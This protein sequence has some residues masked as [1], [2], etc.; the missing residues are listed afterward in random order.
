[1]FSILCSGEA[2]FY[3][4]LTMHYHCVEGHVPGLN[5]VG[6]DDNSWKCS[7]KGNALQQSAQAEP[8]RAGSPARAGSI[9]VTFLKGFARSARERRVC[10]HSSIYSRAFVLCLKPERPVTGRDGDA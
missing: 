2:G 3:H 5:I 10:R 4:R 1:M 7:A 8:T 9:T 6:A